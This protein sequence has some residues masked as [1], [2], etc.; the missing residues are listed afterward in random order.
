M[1]HRAGSGSTGYRSGRN[2]WREMPVAAS[3]ARTRLAGI[4]LFMRQSWIACGYTPSARARAAWLPAA[5]HAR[6]RISMPPSIKH[7]YSGLS[8]IA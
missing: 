3:I 2:S 5:L 8:S 1:S 7:Y 4:L 6:S